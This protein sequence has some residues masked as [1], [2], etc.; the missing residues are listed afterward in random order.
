MA[1][2]M[3]SS[4]VLKHYHRLPSKVQKR[5][6]ELIDAFQRDPYADAIGLHPLNE[7][8]LDPKVRGVTKLPDGSGTSSL[9]LKKGT[10]TSSCTLTATITPTMGA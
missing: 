9:R 8:M 10:P 2:L 3:M 5:V 6:A 1:Q 7:T 4:Q